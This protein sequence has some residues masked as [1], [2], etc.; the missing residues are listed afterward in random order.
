MSVTAL[1]VALAVVVA[2]T[3]RPGSRLGR[4]SR[5]RHLE[6][7]VPMWMPAAVVLVGLATVAGWPVAAA[8]AV[9]GGTVTVRWNRRRRRRDADCAVA[10]LAAGLE[11]MVAELA[12]GAHPAAA[13][14]A[15]AE[16]VSGPVA[17]RFAAAAATAR[18]GGVLSD[19]EGPD[20]HWNRV[21]AV[22][23]VAERHGLGLG[24]LMDAV[25]TDLESRARFARRTEAALSGARATA[26]VLAA[27]PVLGIGLGQAMGASPLAVLFGGGLGGTLLLIGVTLACAGLL[28]TDAIVAKVTA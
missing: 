10:S 22:W 25:R 20:P 4:S 8:A 2:P 7:P 26:T 6:V 24:A 1:L 18:L 3:V 23:R 13:C 27:L 5:R 12:V 11:T 17:D 19:A 16:E 9:L 21:V 14:E 15:A 28:W